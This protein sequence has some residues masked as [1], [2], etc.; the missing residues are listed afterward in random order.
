MGFLPPARFAPLPAPDT[1]FALILRACFG[2]DVL[3]MWAIR[4][5]PNYRM[6]LDSNSTDG[7]HT[8]QYPIVVVSRC[9]RLSIVLPDT[10]HVTVQGGFAHVEV[11]FGRRA[12]SRPRCRACAAHARRLPD[13]ISRG[14]C[15][16]GAD[17]ATAEDEGLWGEVEGGEGEYRRKR[18]NGI[19]KIHERM[20]E[21]DAGL[22]RTRHC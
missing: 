6:E 2:L 22:S 18:R 5:S 17:A 13:E 11:R 16:Q 19:P 4:D 10:A 9:V 15:S 20:S 1:D 14:G 21:E 12:R 8:R 7:R 3:A